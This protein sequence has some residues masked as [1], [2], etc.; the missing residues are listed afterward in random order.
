MVASWNA[1]VCYGIFLYGKFHLCD[2]PCIF[3]RNITLFNKAFMKFVFILLIM[4]VACTADAQQYDPQKV[5]P[6][7][8]ALYSQSLQE[9]TDGNLREG[10]S[11]LRQAITIDKSFEDAFLSM[12]GMYSQ[13]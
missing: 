1:A 6:K 2:E 12:A 8:A 9:A 7:A 10:I 11:L 4:V 13:L 3:N 5:N